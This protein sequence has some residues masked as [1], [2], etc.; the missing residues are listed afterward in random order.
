MSRTNYLTRLF[1]QLFGG[2]EEANE[3]DSMVLEQGYFESILVNEKHE[4]DKGEFGFSVLT[5]P[6]HSRDETDPEIKSAVVFLMQNLRLIDEIG[7]MPNG[8]IGVFMVDTTKRAAERF[9]ARLC[10][11]RQCPEMMKQAQII[12][13]PEDAE[14]LF[15][16]KVI[17]RRVD[18]LPLDLEAKVVSADAESIAKTKDVSS[19]GA[20]LL[21]QQPLT[22]DSEVDIEISLPFSEVG[23]INGDNV[24]LRTKG[25]VIRS[26][27]GGTAVEFTHECDFM[28]VDS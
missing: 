10:N 25:R 24:V 18:R 23:N 15:G 4:A 14:S 8:R 9:M 19:R 12:T 26:D 11:A 21:T 3:E 5:M 16:D 1:E 22:E 7:W 27:G 13:Y 6:M 20:Y 28:N 2:D 17:R